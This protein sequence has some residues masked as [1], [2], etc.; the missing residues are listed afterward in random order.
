MASRRMSVATAKNE[1]SNIDKDEEE[2]LKEL[3]AY[4]LSLTPEDLEKVIQE[5]GLI[6]VVC[7]EKD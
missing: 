4:L 6:E 3:A 1:R 2:G 7:D 5:D